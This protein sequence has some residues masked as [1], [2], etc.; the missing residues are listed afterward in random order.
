M[1][2]LFEFFKEN[3]SK[4]HEAPPAQV[5]NKLEEK[6]EKR[7]RR[8]R[9]GIRFLQLGYVIAAVLLLLVIAF[10]VVRNLPR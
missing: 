6:L 10:L 3:E 2:D 5:W 9:R 4:L 8:T 7:K 1:S